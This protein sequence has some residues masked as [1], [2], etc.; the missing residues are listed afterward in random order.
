MTTLPVCRALR[1][2]IPKGSMRSADDIKTVMPSTR[3]LLKWREQQRATLSVDLVYQG[4]KKDTNT[5]LKTHLLPFDLKKHSVVV[6]F[7]FYNVRQK[8]LITLIETGYC[9][10][11][12]NTFEP[13]KSHI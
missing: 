8:K 6:K 5:R 7:M 2:N 1:G 11:N 12:C 9:K 4:K 10:D 3:P 13:I